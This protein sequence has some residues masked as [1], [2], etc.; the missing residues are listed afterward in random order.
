MNLKGLN[1]LFFVQVFS[2]MGA[3]FIV[4]SSLLAEVNLDAAYKR[5]Y[6]FLNS[7]K[8]TLVEQKKALDERYEKALRQAQGRIG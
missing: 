3:I 2:L 6:I 1:N 4:S 8:K 5:E 7:Q